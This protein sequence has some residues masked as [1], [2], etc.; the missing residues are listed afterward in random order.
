MGYFLGEDSFWIEIGLAI[1][2]GVGIGLERQMSG[3]PIG[4]RTSTLICLATTTFVH[5]GRI[6]GAPADAI[7]V[8]GQVVVGVGFL[9]AGL[10]INQSGVVT[11]VTSAAVVWVLAAV[12]AST[13]LGQYGYATILSLMT[14]VILVGVQRVEDWIEALK[15]GIYTSESKK[16]GS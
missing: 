15:K 16:N 8:V 11:G 6:T 14:I 13:G 5:L 7:R 10:I 3:K 1:L 2:F 4:V 12:G 9:G